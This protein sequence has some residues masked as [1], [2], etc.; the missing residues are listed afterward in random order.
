MPDGIKYISLTIVFVA[1]IKVIQVT[2]FDS[3]RYE[4]LQRESASTGYSVYSTKAKSKKAPNTSK[5]QRKVTAESKDDKQ[6]QSQNV[7]DNVNE[8]IVVSA[9]SE[10]RSE[11]TLSSLKNSYLAP[12]LARIPAGQLRED[13]VIRYYR[14]KKDSNKV[15][16]LKGLSYYIHEKEAEETAGLGS[17]IIYYGDDVP[18]EDI[19]IIAFTLLEEGFPLK[20][21]KHTQF[22]WKAKAVEIGT[23]TTL[24]A[25]PI[26]LVQDIQS[27]DKQYVGN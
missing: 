14:H 12:L 16:K 17:N 15:D 2:M 3:K 8:S 1:I 6:A 21:I 4:A 24:L 7:E 26:M 13:I 11:T 10:N 25:E 23:D 20:S 18:L 22:K 9:T 19:Q 5:S 27:F